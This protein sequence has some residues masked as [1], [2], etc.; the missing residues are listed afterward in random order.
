MKRSEISRSTWKRKFNEAYDKKW[1]SRGKGYTQQAFADEINKIK[2][3]KYGI[4]ATIDNRCV[5]KW[6]NGTRPEKENLDC[7]CE[8]LGLP[9]NHFE[10]S[11]RD[12]YRDS[13][14]F[15]TA[16]GRDNVDFAKEKGLDL[17]FVKGLQNVVDFDSLFPL[18]SRIIVDNSDLLPTY[19]RQSN[20]A[21][22]APIDDELDFL[23][24]HRGDKTLTFH[25]CDL[26]YL[27]EV[28][29]QVVEFVEFLFYKRHEEMKREVEEINKRTHMKTSNG[30]EGF[31]PLHQDEMLEIDRLIQYAYKDAPEEGGQDNGKH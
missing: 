29:D 15:I 9:I 8:V 28:Q 2:T 30:G 10:P 14:K 31:R 21:D 23:Q 20:F 19:K 27:R 5:S 13:S 4:Q 17:D 22:S 26:A 3:E 18:Y 7:I 11:D 24:I 16:L 25:R 1:K 6:A 12:L